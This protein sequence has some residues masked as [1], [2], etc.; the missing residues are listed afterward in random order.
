MLKRSYVK[1]LALLIMYGTALMMG[2][3]LFLP[4]LIDVNE[5]RD[6]IIAIAEKA[7]QRKVSFS[8]GR[9]KMIIGP[10]FVFDDVV[11][12][13]KDGQSN[14]ISAKQMT[15]HLAILP[16]LEKRVALR[17]LLLESPQVHLQRAADGKTN[18][19]DLIKPSAGETF[20]IQ[21]R[22]VKVKNGTLRL[23]DAAVQQQPL[24]VTIAKVNLSLDRMTRG[25]KGSFKISAELPSG[26][27]PLCSLALSGTAR[28]ADEDKSLSETELNATIDLKNA[29]PGRF[30]GYYGRFIPFGNTG[31][32]V[33][34]SSTFKGK[35][36]AFSAK[37]KL[38]LAGVKVIWPTVFHHPVDPKLAE[39]DYE[40]QLGKDSL[41]MPRL[42][43]SADGFRIKGSCNLTDLHSG[44]LK[45]TAKANSEPFVLENLRQWIPYGIIAKDASEWIEEHI[46]GGTFR[47]ETGSLDG[48]ISQIVHM[49]KGTNYNVL[50]IKGTVEKGI[51]SYGPKVPEF[52]NISAGLE[53]LGKDFIL[54]NVKASFGGSPLTM[55]G[56]ITDYPL[57]KPCEYP[58]QMDITPRSAEVAWL[59][60][61]A[62]I[63]KLDYAGSSR[64][65]LSG[66]GRI[67]AY[68]LSGAWDLKQ[69][70]Y[71]YPDIIKKPAGMA[72][73]LSF[74]AVL[75]KT[76]TRLSSLSYMLA[77]L[78]LSATALFAYGDKPRLDF[79]VQTNQFQL[80]DNLPIMT[81][82]QQYKPRG[83]VK[84]HVFGSGSPQDFNTMNYRGDIVLSAFSLKP[85]DRLKPISNMNGTISLKGRSLETSNIGIMLGSSRINAKG[86]ISD[87]RNPETEL[88]L[89][90]PELLLSDVA[91]ISHLPDTR[92]R[93]V[94]CRLGIKEH[95][96]RIRN[97]SAALNGTPFSIN[98]IYSAGAPSRLN[99]N[100]ASANLDVD[101]VILVSRMDFPGGDDKSGGGTDLR[102]RMAAEKGHFGNMKFSKLNGRMVQD[103]GVIYITSLDALLYGGRLTAK[104]RIAP[105]SDQQ[106]HRFAA[107]FNLKNVNADGF[108]K[109]IDFTKEVTG[110]LDLEGD[111]TGL[112][113][114]WQDVKRSALGNLRLKLEDGTLRK[115][116]VLSKMFSILNVSQLLKFQL[117]DMV[118]GGMPYDEITGSIAVK[119]GRAS[120]SD[121]F[122]SS[123]AINISIVGDTDVVNEDLNL[124][125]GVQPLQ[126]VDK[127][128]NR[129]PVIG[130]LLTG[131][132][133]DVL[134]AYFEAKGKWADPQVKPIQVKSMGQGILN[135]FRRAFELPV[136]LFTD[137]GEVVLGQ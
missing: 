85:G 62:G 117:P 100:I 118:A 53:M 9:F 108:F 22:R 64:L 135:I 122:I 109:S 79:E 89:T 36:A 21:L 134:T 25:Q 70:L 41:E 42:H 120:S 59:A 28:V 67:S 5:Y 46:T 14:F 97:L 51:V 52:N 13:E 114:S 111:L 3:S 75:G 128:V 88:S 90:S 23:H 33:D 71:S 63:E 107:S 136:R 31:G 34:L 37:G 77:P 58:F 19:D 115:F 96:Y 1:L 69:G 119:D 123:D 83:R 60:R 68:R 116:G 106:G 86:S 12:R 57:D 121:L 74:S 81:G 47:L 8:N 127:I 50:H 20:K 2:L 133:S 104:G 30:W 76:E 87:L 99:L 93:N 43:F 131:K 55:D 56:R 103:G 126:T 26:T 124:T 32:R 102:I 72:N 112:G 129:I 66:S 7:L 54:S 98:G 27:G 61:L 105:G 91:I 78:N 40:L 16:L 95:N 6:D 10:A 65:Q 17:D 110:T 113:N 125:I 137:T 84:A 11:V 49:E 38:R 35:A 73:T 24:E 80:G 4:Y 39:L 48:R 132:D 18:V 82:W 94:S 92:I 45:I 15:V 29:E 101:D 44:D 130:W